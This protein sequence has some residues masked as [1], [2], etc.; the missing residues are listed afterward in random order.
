MQ[1]DRWKLGCGTNPDTGVQC[2]AFEFEQ[3]ERHRLG[4]KNVRPPHV[5]GVRL[6]HPVYDLGAAWILFIRDTVHVAEYPECGY[7]VD[8]GRRAIVVGSA[9]WYGLI[10]LA[11]GVVQ[12]FFAVRSG[13]FVWLMS[14]AG[15]LYV[16]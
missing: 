13:G 11:V 6:V 7:M 9:G 2:V 10:R 1:L 16:F 3:S 15:Q 5:F 14:C 4:S 8:T 12:R